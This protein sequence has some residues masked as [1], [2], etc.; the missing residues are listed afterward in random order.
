MEGGKMRLSVAGLAGGLLAVALAT[1]GCGTV[2]NAA[3]S[4]TSLPPHTAADATACSDAHAIAEGITSNQ[5]P[6]TQQLRT[7]INDAWSAND[8]GVLAAGRAL[9][10]SVTKQDQS[11][12]NPAFLSLQHACQRLGLW[13]NWSGSGN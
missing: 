6:S 7:M 11:A 3:M 10:Q 4:A 2:I 13:P 9:N 12:F 5:N 8:S 1:S